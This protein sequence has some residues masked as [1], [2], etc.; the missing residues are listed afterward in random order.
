MVED[1]RGYPQVCLSF[2]V[3]WGAPT[4]NKPRVELHPG[5]TLMGGPSNAVH[6]EHLDH[7]HN[8]KAPL[9]PRD[10]HGVLPGPSWEPT[11]NFAEKN[12]TSRWSMVSR[13][14]NDGES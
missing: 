10:S 14:A 9:A 8:L 3:K 11:A 4:I 2:P 12:E 5:L 13:V 1:H 6:I 7:V